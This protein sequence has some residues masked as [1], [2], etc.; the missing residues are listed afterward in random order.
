[1]HTPDDE[2]S[3]LSAEEVTVREA[4]ETHWRR[5]VDFWEEAW[6]RSGPDAPGFTGA[7]EEVIAELATQEAFRA[8]IGGPDRRMF[9]A[10]E[11]DRV[12]GF[13]ATRRVDVGTVELAG[14]IVLP[15]LAGRGIGTALLDAAVARVGR[16]GYRSMT[17][18]TET[19]NR[20]A[21]AFYERRGFRALR[22]AVEQVG[23]LPVAVW[24][25]ARS[26]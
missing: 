5:F 6:R 3:D 2:T 24:E 16:D 15:S 12:V 20:P 8:R 11:N 17:V 4:S 19:T 7:T 22:T 21:R 1:M 14:V 10:W 18:R 23:D 26:L 25:L 13:A 9:L